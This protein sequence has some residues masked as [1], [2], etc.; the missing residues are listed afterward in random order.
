MVP[1]VSKY[2]I[3]HPMHFL[4]SVKSS[5]EHKLRSLQ[6]RKL[7]SEIYALLSTDECTFQQ[8]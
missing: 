5:T 1:Y 3:S 7:E 6:V 2:G 4:V 8:S